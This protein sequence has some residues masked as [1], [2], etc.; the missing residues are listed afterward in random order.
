MSPVQLLHYS[1]HRNP[2]PM[3]RYGI[4]YSCG[5][6][7]MTGIACGASMRVRSVGPCVA[8]SLGHSTASAL[9]APVR[10]KASTIRIANRKKVEMFVGKRYHLPTRLRVAAPDI[11]A[12][13]DQEKNPLHLYPDIVSIGYMYPVFWKCGKC[14]NSY[15]MSVEKRVVRGRGCPV[16]EDRELSA[17][18]AF[19]TAAMNAGNA[20]SR[21][22][23]IA[24]VAA[25][26]PLLPGEKNRSLRPK[27][28][29]MLNLRTKY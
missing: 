9:H 22:A 18:M 11:A 25:T 6:G 16:C 8:S 14:T 5:A 23:D 29:T 19:N 7:R 17:S 15:E 2:L 13:W 1:E 12:E 4:P 24:S 26:P 21:E 28:T 20:H 10:H 27:R 3:F